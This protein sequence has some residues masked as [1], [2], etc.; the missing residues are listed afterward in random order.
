LTKH[1]A[2]QD[3]DARKHV[4]RAR[5][6]LDALKVPDAVLRDAARLCA[7]VG[8]D[9]VRG[10]LALLRGARALAA[11]D[12]ARSVTTA[13]LRTIAP[14]ALRHRLRR[15]VLDDVGSSVRIERAVADVLG[16]A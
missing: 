12:G 7:A 1:W 4:E 16:A 11:Y 13:H 3:L 2:A 15:N 10:E 6:K 5:K 9:G 14:S 8:T